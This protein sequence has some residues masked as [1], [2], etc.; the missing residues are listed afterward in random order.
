M[1]GK[2]SSGEVESQKKRSPKIS[3]KELSASTIKKVEESVRDVMEVR[4]S[5]LFKYFQSLQQIETQTDREKSEKNLL[6]LQNAIIEENMPKLTQLL[7]GSIH[8]NEISGKT[9]WT[10]LHIAAR[11]GKVPFTFFQVEI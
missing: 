9:G 4:N 3:H 5:T 10:P 1:G 8:I 11:E 2:G 7:Q 6:E